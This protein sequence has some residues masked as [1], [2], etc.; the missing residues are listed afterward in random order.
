M[1]CPVC[2]HVMIVV[3]Y[4]NIELDHCH[5][6]KGVWF[7]SGELELLLKSQ[8]LEEPKEFFEGIFNSQEAASSEKKRKCPICGRKMKKTAIGG[9]PE[10]LID[11]CREQHGLWFDRGEVA[12]L[13]KRLAGEH[14][15]KHDSRGH[16]T[17]FLKEILEASQ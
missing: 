14:P 3:E 1:I 4:R 11:V 2:R 6:C 13:I 5:N 7:D 9:Q 17:G 16:V 15:A 8:G 10:I 12:Q